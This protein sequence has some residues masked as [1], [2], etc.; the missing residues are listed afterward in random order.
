MINIPTGFFQST[1]AEDPSGPTVLSPNVI[2]FLRH[3]GGDP[4]QLNTGTDDSSSTPHTA[5][6]GVERGHGGSWYE[7]ISCELYLGFNET[8]IPTTISNAK[9][10]VVINPSSA[11]DGDY[12]KFWINNQNRRTKTE[13]DSAISAGT[14]TWGS[15][16][17][18]G[19][20]PGGV[21]DSWDEHFNGGNALVV[22]PGTPSI[23]EFEFSASEIAWLQDWKNSSSTLSY[24][25]VLGVDTSSNTI[26][27][28]VLDNSITLTFNY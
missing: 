18:T 9:L 10:K 21:Y 28:L 1:S 15:F 22:A 20:S 26:K 14:F 8:Q 16:L 13:I 17:P 2:W 7:G 25:I 12:I 23:Q 6:T 5:L 4:S 19:F 11:F 27:K 3:G 24:G